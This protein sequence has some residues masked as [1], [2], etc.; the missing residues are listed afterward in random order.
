[1]LRA[2][3]GRHGA[4]RVAAAGHGSAALVGPCRARTVSLTARRGVVLAGPRGSLLTAPTCVGARKLPTC[5]CARSLQPPAPTLPV[6]RLAS[7]SF[8]GG[9]IR[10]GGRA[11]SRLGT[12]SPSQSQRARMIKRTFLPPCS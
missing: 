8:C 7:R 11:S 2:G 1:V 5:G 9:S 4:G 10:A 12:C 6:L 3:R